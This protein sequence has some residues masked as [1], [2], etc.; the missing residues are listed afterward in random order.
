MKISFLIAAHNEEK[1]IGKALTN[2]LNL[3]YDS[4]EILIGLDGCTDKTEEIVQNFMKKSKRIQYYTLNLR[5]GKPAVINFLAKKAT[6]D[7]IIIHD[8]DWVFTVKSKKHLTRFLAVF[9][10][11]KIGGIAESFPIEFYEENPYRGNLGYQ[12]VM[13]SAYYWLSFQKRNYT[14]KKNNLLYVDKPK[15]F[16]T[17]I[18]LRELYENVDSL[19]DDFERTITIIKRKYDVVL[20]QDPSLPRMKAIYNKINIYDLFKQKVRTA[21]AREQIQEK[22]GPITLRYYAKA[23]FSILYESLK[24]SPYL[25]FVTFLWIIVTTV[26]TLQS[27]FKKMNT[28]EGW[29]LRAQR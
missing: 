23:N 1:L 25:G 24:K 5:Q 21:L 12:M 20:F 13:Y 17:N 6:G 2:L 10:N 27:K 3:P 15:L 11:K 4:Y 9:K 14:Y 7:L 16:M 18:L 8:A 19:G 29:I 28:R 26:A 22:E